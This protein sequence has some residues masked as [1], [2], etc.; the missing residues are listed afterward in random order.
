MSIVDL[1]VYAGFPALVLGLLVAFYGSYYSVHQDLAGIT[2]SG[3][4]AIELGQQ[5]SGYSIYFP[6][7]ERIWYSIAV[8]LSDLTGLRLD[9]AAVVMTYVLVLVGCSL[10]YRIRQVAVGATPLFFVVSLAC[11][12]LVPILYK[13]LFGLREHI[14]AL[15]LWPY[16]VLRVSDPAGERVGRPLRLM[17]GAWLG[18]TLLLKYLYSL[19]VMLVELVDAGHACQF[20]RLFRIEN[21]VAGSIVAAYLFVWLVLDPA[22]RTAIGAVASAI[23]ANLAGRGK[24]WFNAMKQLPMAVFLLAL[25]R[26]YKLPSRTTLFGFALIAGTMAVAAIQARWYTHHIFPITLAYLAWWWMVWRDFSLWGNATA[27]LLT[28]MQIV[29]QYYLT[30]S[31]QSEV[32]ELDASME[33]AGLSVSGQRVGVLTVHPS[34]YN[35]YLALH[36]ALRWNASMNNSYVAAELKPFD[37][38]ENKGVAPPPVKLEEPGRKMLH[39]EMLRLWEDMPADV[40]ILD[41]SKRWPLRYIDVEWM[42]V[43][44]EDRRFNAIIEGYKPVL[45]HRG[46]R[47][48]FTYYVRVDQDRSVQLQQQ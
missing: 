33:K 20:N 16:L 34:P 7:A 38:P 12:I 26:L 14:V 6:P 5:F 1:G 41:H 25:S 43:F 24:S 37:L 30:N 45:H 19:V 17:V 44:S 48:D 15:G 22:Q 13:N 42:Q 40:L 32:R 36:D 10:A 23:D 47:L 2:L 3:K 18:L 8:R 9:L 21:F 46:A 4:L 27:A 28:A 11:F 31:Y 29:P 35:E 39:D